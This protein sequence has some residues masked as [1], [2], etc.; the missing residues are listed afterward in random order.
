MM[1]ESATLLNR[2]TGG[3]SA[4]GEKTYT[5]DERTTQSF[6]VADAVTDQQRT[7][8]I[9]VSEMQVVFFLSDQDILV[10][11][12]DNAGA[13]GSIALKAGVPFVERVAADQYHTAKLAVDVTDTYWTNASGATANVQ[14]GVIQNNTP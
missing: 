2:F 10:E 8:T 4:S 7:L 14:V 13:Q 3:L 1:S 5:G 9:D 11:W 12:N 6:T